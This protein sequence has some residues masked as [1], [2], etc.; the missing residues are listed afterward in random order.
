[1]RIFRGELIK[2]IFNKTVWFILL[3]FLAISIF[4]FAQEAHSVTK[5]NSDLMDSYSDIPVEEAINIARKQRETNDL[6]LA[7]QNFRSVYQDEQLAEEAL[8]EYASSFYGENVTISEFLKSQSEVDVSRLEAEYEQLYFVIS[9]LEYVQSYSEFIAS[10]KQRTQDMLKSSLFNSKETYALRNILKTQSDFDDMKDIKLSIGNDAGIVTMSNFIY[11]D[12]LLIAFVFVLSYYIFSV[13]R[14]QGL[15]KIL[16]STAKG[17]LPVI[18]SKIVVLLL[19]TFLGFTVIYGSIILMTNK[20]LGF[21]DLS[22]YI[23]SISVFRDCSIAL[24]VV[25]YLLFFLFIKLL[26]ILLVALILALFFQLSKSS[27]LIYILI[28]GFSC[29]EYLLYTLIHPASVLNLLKYINVFS[30][31][32]T[33]GMFKIYTNINFFGYPHGR[34]Y[35]TIVTAIIFIVLLGMMNLKLFTMRWQGFTIPQFV[36]KLFRLKKR[37][38]GSVSLLYHELYKTF[39]TSK[40]IDAILGLMVISYVS[41]DR[42]PL[43]VERETSSYLTFINKYEGE[44]TDEKSRL[45]QEEIN[46]INGIPNRMFTISEDYKNGDITKELYQKEFNLL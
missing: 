44:L 39:F 4:L 36:H 15:L 25:E 17:R 34:V 29:V 26:V 1:M 8:L 7:L 27:T 5:M 45:I 6:Q 11:G 35:L 31:L 24:T 12:I 33:F 32:D 20:M 3:S 16:K 13:E 19:L 22:R 10:M 23:Q 28:L 46:Y 38:S 40:R 30:F 2:H 21:G 43:Y 42:I 37:N 41:I 9:Q 14:E 18:F